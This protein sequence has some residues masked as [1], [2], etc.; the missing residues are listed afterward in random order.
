MT[1]ARRRTRTAHTRVHTKRV[2]DPRQAPVSATSLSASCAAAS[3]CRPRVLHGTQ[4]RVANR[5]EALTSRQWA[6]VHAL[7][8]SARVETY[9]T[10][11]AEQLL[12]DAAA[13][14]KS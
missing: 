12:C 7:M 13:F 11:F 9:L 6:G 2:R 10:P 4:V 5:Y 3:V 8:G 1:H 14:R